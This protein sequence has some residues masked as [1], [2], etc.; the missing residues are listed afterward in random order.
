MRSEE[1]GS[2][3]LGRPLYSLPYHVDNGL[4]L[5]VTPSPSLPLLLRSR[6]NT[7]VSAASLSPDSVL[8]LLGRGLTHW[9]LQSG[10]A[11]LT[12]GRHAV[13]SLSG[14]AVRTRTI[15][16]RMK[17]APLAA[18]PIGRPESAPFRAIFMGDAAALRSPAS[19]CEYGAPLTEKESWTGRARREAA[20]CWPHTGEGCGPRTWNGR[21]CTDADRVDA[22][23]GPGSC[24]SDSGCPLC[25]PFCSRSGYCQ[26][27][28]Q[29]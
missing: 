13:P 28:R 17:V 10:A 11:V 1:E 22:G 18:R 7:A 12:P 24:N 3:T 25:A 15:V 26:N 20:A 23:R 29:G 14:G 2:S 27:Q 19:L 4:Y 6:Y 16:A 9:L 8:V 21:A 5:L